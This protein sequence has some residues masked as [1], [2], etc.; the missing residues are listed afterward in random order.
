MFHFLISCSYLFTFLLSSQF[1]W[2]RPIR[3]KSTAYFFDQPCR[4]IIYNII[5]VTVITTNQL[6]SQKA[7]N[8]R[9]ISRCRLELDSSSRTPVNDR[10]GIRVLRTK[11]PSFAQPTIV[12]LT[13][14][15][16]FWTVRS[17]HVFQCDCSHWVLELV[18][19]SFQAL[20]TSLQVGPIAYS[21]GP[22][23]PKLYFEF[24][25]N[26]GLCAIADGKR[27][28]ILFVVSISDFC[29]FCY[30]LITWSDC[31][32]CLVRGVCLPVH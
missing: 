31:R 22:N 8:A 15:T 24:H 26:Q 16:K 23:R 6:A 12:T 14:V 27:N 29:N 21:R 18:L 28:V 1:Y 4:S 25:W 2:H 9:K 10:V 7:S 11:R 19:S 3:L 5:V 32:G 17:G 30:E 13:R 20:W